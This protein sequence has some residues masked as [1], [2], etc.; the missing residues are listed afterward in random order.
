MSIYQ[1]MGGTNGNQK[2]IDIHGIIGMERH[3]TFSKR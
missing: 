1:I 2:M 3:S